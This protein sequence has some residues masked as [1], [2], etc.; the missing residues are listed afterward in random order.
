MHNIAIKLFKALIYI[1]FLSI[2]YLLGKHES[3]PLYYFKRD[4]DV[5]A[6]FAIF[7]NLFIGWYITKIIG[8]RNDIDKKDKDIILN[9]LEKNI[10]NWEMFINQVHTNSLKYVD[11]TSFIKRN[12]YAIERICRSFKK[13]HSLDYT[14]IKQDIDKTKRRLLLLMT[15]T[16]TT[17]NIHQ[18]IQEPV[19]I[20][21]DIITYTPAR[22]DEILSEIDK[23]IDSITQLELLI[24]SK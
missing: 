9:R 23:M 11:V 2:G 18:N 13:Y 12:T 24:N 21:N 14:I 6:I 5:V 8:K 16:G 1:I 7:S 15:Y 22:I 3:F 10:S 4:L 17:V 19:I 20:I